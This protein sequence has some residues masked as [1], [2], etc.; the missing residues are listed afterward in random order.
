MAACR[1]HTA[2]VATVI[3]WPC[4]TRHEGSKARLGL[5]RG[6]TDFGLIPAPNFISRHFID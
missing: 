5:R 2:Q 1:E 6:W 4:Y 3:D